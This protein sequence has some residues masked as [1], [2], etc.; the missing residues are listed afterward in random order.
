MSVGREQLGVRLASQL[1]LWSVRLA[2]FLAVAR[3]VSSVHFH[4]AVFSSTEAGT[5][6]A[7]KA[8]GCASGC[9]YSVCF[10]SR[11]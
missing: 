3:D 10:C 4:F 6:V 8:V 2:G 9:R 1:N 7:P 11:F 5:A